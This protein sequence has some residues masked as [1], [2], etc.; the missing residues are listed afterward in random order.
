MD[1]DFFLPSANAVDF[2]DD[3]SENELGSALYS[4]DVSRK[5]IDQPLRNHGTTRLQ[6]VATPRPA[7]G[8][9]GITV[10]TDV[11]SKFSENSEK[12][13]NVAI[14]MQRKKKR[15]MLNSNGRKA[16][17]KID[18]L[19]EQTHCGKE[20]LLQTVKYFV[21]K[22]RVFEIRRI[23]RKIQLLKKKKGTE[24]ELLKNE[25]KIVRFLADVEILKNI[26]ID[27]LC[28]KCASFIEEKFQFM[29]HEQDQSSED[30]KWLK[31]LT[32]NSS[33]DDDISLILK[34][35]SL[36]GV[37][38]KFEVDISNLFKNRVHLFNKVHGS[39][40]S[41]QDRDKIEERIEDGSSAEN[42][43][44]RKV[45]K[46]KRKLIEIDCNGKEVMEEHFEIKKKSSKL[47]SDV[48]LNVAKNLS[49]PAK[50]GRNCKPTVNK[51]KN[52]SSLDQSELKVK[53]FKEKLV[54]MRNKHGNRLGQRARQE[55]WEK[56]YG[57][58]AAHVKKGAKSRRDD[59]RKKERVNKNK[60]RSQK[61]SDD[62]SEQSKDKSVSN[63]EENL[64]P[65]WQA[66][67]FQKQQN[68]IVPFEGSKIKFDD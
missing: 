10:T 1:D 39:D 58:D 43:Q 3:D 13:K 37:S 51:T 24:Q 52:D 18:E 11:G 65:S 36:K 20:K 34:L 59:K 28:E 21:K 67:K 25:R 2:S 23:T 32:D 6:G 54:K 17:H 57:K 26:N 22:G 64:H 60:F 8:D 46:I 35:L 27:S 12:P 5:D 49:Q 63:I 31:L 15:K 50:K 16:I 53:K 33:L 7:G 48:K 30:L 62:K 68:Q 47:K 41:G 45:G 38:T 19:N 55:L 4:N 66:K 61:N 9:D 42:Q 29:I 14:K 56:M 44:K 40:E